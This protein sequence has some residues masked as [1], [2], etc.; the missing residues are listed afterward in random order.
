MNSGLELS[1][2][3]SSNPKPLNKKPPQRGG[4]LFAFKA[5]LSLELWLF[6]VNKYNLFTSAN[7][8]DVAAFLPSLE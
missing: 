7:L 8:L 2:S 3:L 5:L 1:G 4:F 6:W